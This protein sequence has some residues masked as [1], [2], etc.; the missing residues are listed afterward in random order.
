MSVFKYSDE[1]NKPDTQVKKSSQEIKTNKEE[2]YVLR[3]SVKGQENIEKSS[4][5]KDEG[6][7]N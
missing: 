1:E 3:E 5:N 6:V 4:F 7:K 2:P